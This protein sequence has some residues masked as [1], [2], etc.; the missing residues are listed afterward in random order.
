MAESVVWGDLFVTREP[1]RR[2]RR[3]NGMRN[4]TALVLV[5]LSLVLGACAEAANDDV[6]NVVQATS[7]TTTAAPSRGQQLPTDTVTP[8]PQGRPA[9]GPFY[10]D[11]A[12]LSVAESF[13]IQVFV[14]IEGNQPTP[15]DEVDWIVTM[16]DD[17]IDIELYTVAN[18]A[19]TCIAVLHPV[20]FTIPVG[21][22]DSGQY[23]VYINGDEIGYFEV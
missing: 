12:Q 21:S 2:K 1:Q 5:A 17:R 9:T 3:Q 8:E 16:G 6:D 7:T 18:P 10:L 23:T 19:A 22:F 14:A 11:S 15:C 20:S 4:T 13:P